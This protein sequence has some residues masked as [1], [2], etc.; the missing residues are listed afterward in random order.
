MQIARTDLMPCLSGAL[1][2]PAYKALLV[3]DLHLE[4]GSAGAH[5]GLLLPPYDTRMGL[6]ALRAAMQKWLP[7]QVILLGDS[8]HDVAGPVRMDA[9]DL[10]L[11]EQ[12]T[13]MA[14]FTWLSGNHDPTLPEDIPGLHAS[15][16]MLG[17]ITLRHEPKPGAHDEIAG[18]L[19][20]VACLTQR[21][22][23]L[24]SRCFVVSASRVIMPAFG[25]YTG[26]LDVRHD[27][28]RRLLPGDAFRTVMVGRNALH[29][30]PG[31]A[32]L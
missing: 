26:G 19:H 12:L 13:G 28:F 4:K 31:R 29:T 11:L 1:Y 30:L 5:R 6:L 22:R 18:H 24:R 15:E 3:A 7:D 21:G 14:R 32:V 9:S 23:R 20:P 25:A 2:V 8:F 27:A 10:A 17:A 16:M